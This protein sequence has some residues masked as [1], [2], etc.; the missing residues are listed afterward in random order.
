MKEIIVYRYGH[1]PARDKRITT[2]VALTA[3]AMGAK[4]I[5]IDVP[6]KGIEEN[7]ASV[8]RNFGG[9][10]SVESGVGINKFMSSADENRVIIHLTMYG[11]PIGTK[12]EGIKQRIEQ[13]DMAYIFVGAEKVPGIAYIKSDFNVSVTN[14]PISEVSALAILLDRINEGRE[15]TM[16]IHGRLKISGHERGKDVTFYPDRKDCMDILLKHGANEWLIEHSIAVNSIAM[17]I[18]DK[19]ECNRDAVDAGSF[20]HDIGRTVRNDIWHSYEGYE[21]CRS[22]R[23]ADE[24]CNCIL[25]HTGAGIEK[26]EADQLGIPPMNYM[27]ETIEEKIVATADNLIHGAERISIVDQLKRYEEKNLHKA[28]ERMN[29][30]FEEISHKSGFDLDSLEI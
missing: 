16:N 29:T 4:G 7:I 17:K 27:P 24:I 22:E 25:K 15:L 11:E 23:I 13:A 2:H 9:D 28:A 14:Q 8:N 20:L 1:R 26:E 12:I 5:I 10:F 30:L 18:C 21:I 6:D 19:V 3:R